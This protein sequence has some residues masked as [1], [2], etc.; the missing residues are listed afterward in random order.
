MIIISSKHFKVN[1]SKAILIMHIFSLYPTFAMGNIEDDLD[2]KNIIES[3]VLSDNGLVT[4]NKILEESTD[5]VLNVED[6]ESESINNDDIADNTSNINTQEDIEEEINIK[7]DT[8]NDNYIDSSIINSNKTNNNLLDKNIDIKK[9][10]ISSDDTALKSLGF[11]WNNPELTETFDP[12]K[13]DYIALVQNNDITIRTYPN[14]YGIIVRDSYATM[15]I[16]FNDDL[17]LDNVTIAPDTTFT[18]VK[19]KTNIMRIVVTA[20]N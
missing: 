4:T 17:V 20:E 9:D 3:P 13:K 18:L 19:N 8:V 11:L 7:E 2:N 14:S 1:C 6:S 5:E 12:N 10:V 15:D 16:Y